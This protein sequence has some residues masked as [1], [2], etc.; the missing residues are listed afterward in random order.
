MSFESKCNFCSKVVQTKTIQSKNIRFTCSKECDKNLR[1]Q[2]QLKL[3]VEKYG[4]KVIPKYSNNYI[5]NIILYFLPSHWFQN[6]VL[7]DKCHK[8]FY[9]DMIPSLCDSC[10][11]FI[12]VTT[13]CVNCNKQYSESTKK[14]KQKNGLC[15]D[16]FNHTDAEFICTICRITYSDTHISY[17]DLNQPICKMCRNSNNIKKNYLHNYV[18][19]NTINEM[20]DINPKKIININFEVSDEIHD[21]YCSDGDDIH[22]E[23]YDISREFPLMNEF[24]ENSDLLKNDKFIYFYTPKSEGTCYLGCGQKSYTIIK[25]E[26]V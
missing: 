7:C 21:G 6:N 23:T 14:I 22:I 2:I 17:N 1:H 20:L 11:Y 19:N 25:Y 16:C 15:T 3:N 4:P 26:I 9:S 18:N 8:R 5:P 24:D 10:N 13:Q 12:P